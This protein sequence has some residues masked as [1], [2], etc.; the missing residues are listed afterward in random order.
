MSWES[1]A[2]FLQ[3]GT[4][5]QPKRICFAD[6]GPFY[7]TPEIATDFL[8][9]GVWAEWEEI[10]SLGYENNDRLFTT[11]EG[12]ETQCDDQFEFV[13]F[14]YR[15]EKWINCDK[16]RIITLYHWRA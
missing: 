15:F 3:P 16:I 2:S 7:R 12:E 4:L 14:Q 8:D 10:L 11:A 6:S 9:R 1:N 5:W 13:M